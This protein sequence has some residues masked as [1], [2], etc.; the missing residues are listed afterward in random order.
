ME[1]PSNIFTTDSPDLAAF[2]QLNG[3][4]YIDCIIEVEPDTERSKGIMRF[5]DEKQNARD[6]ERL[7]LTSEF[8]KYRD[9][10]KF[11][12]REV[13]KAVKRT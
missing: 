9:L 7:F 12:L 1:K 13:H 8:K 2:L 3:I 11:Y 6:L 5:L 10:N 4:K